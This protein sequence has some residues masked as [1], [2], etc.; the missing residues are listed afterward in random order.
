MEYERFLKIT[1]GVKHESEKLNKLYDL[2]IELYDFADPYHGIINELIKE[3]YGEEGYDWWSW[4]CYESDFGHKDWG[5]TSSYK[6]DDKG[7][8]VLLHEAGETRYG[9]H[10]ENGNPIC[11]SF[12]S[13]WDYLEANHRK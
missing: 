2:G 1:L 12:E 8:M 10:D 9:A 13:T 6:K 5:A 4:F 11:H 7:N 3:I